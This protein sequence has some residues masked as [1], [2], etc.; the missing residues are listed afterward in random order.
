MNEERIWIEEQEHRTDQNRNYE[1][2]MEQDRGREY[3]MEKIRYLEP[4]MDQVGG[5]RTQ[6]GL[7]QKL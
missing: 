4:R 5:K 3:R 2:R 1:L 7:E 6:N